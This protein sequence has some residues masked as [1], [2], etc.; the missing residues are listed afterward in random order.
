MGLLPVGSIVKLL[1]SKAATYMI[2]GY[3]PQ[4]E[5]MV[6]DYSAVEYP[7][8]LDASGEMH[9]FYADEIEELLY[10][11]YTDETTERLLKKLPE[12]ITELFEV[13]CEYTEGI[14]R[15]EGDIIEKNNL[16]QIDISM[17]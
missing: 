4:N 15:K 14:R 2:V 11:G 12:Y 1:N 8:G 3:Y 6:W 5:E 10:V 17:I 13:G 7:G 16:E 9:T